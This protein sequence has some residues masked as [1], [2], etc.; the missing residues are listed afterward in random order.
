MANSVGEI[1]K[2][3]RLECGLTQRALAKKIGVAH[4]MV[5]HW[6]N[7]Y[8]M[9]QLLNCWDLADFFKCSLDELCGRN[10]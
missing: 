3:K 2:A 10:I 5:S 7:D 1:I 4:V 8:C 9:P 6:E